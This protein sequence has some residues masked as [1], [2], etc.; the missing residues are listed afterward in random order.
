LAS[1][2][3]TISS[4]PSGRV[5]MPTRAEPFGPDTSVLKFAPVAGVAW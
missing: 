1:T 5:L 2:V 4:R 3:D